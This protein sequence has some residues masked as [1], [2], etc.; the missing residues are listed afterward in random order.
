MS[1]TVAC[2][3]ESFA[4]LTTPTDHHLHTV[5]LDGYTD[6]ALDGKTHVE[7]KLACN[8][9]LVLEALALLRRLNCLE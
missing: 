8:S 2:A 4:L 3:W 9:V 1:L 5:P 6:P 7:A